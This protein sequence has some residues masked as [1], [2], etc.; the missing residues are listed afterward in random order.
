MILVNEA[1]SSSNGK[2]ALLEENVPETPTQD[3]CVRNGLKLAAE[4]WDSIGKN[5][6]VDND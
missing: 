6:G 1:I 3:K 2:F 5:I 4:K